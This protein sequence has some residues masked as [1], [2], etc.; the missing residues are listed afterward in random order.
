MATLPPSTAEV[1]EFRCQWTHNVTQKKKKWNDGSLKF[2]TFNKL[3]RIFDE[4]SNN[5]GQKHWQGVSLQDGDEFQLDNVLVSV[6]DHLRSTQTNLVP[7]FD[8]RK[9]QLANDSGALLDCSHS[10]HVPRA[11]TQA[12]LSNF[13]S[14]L[15]GP[16]Q[17]H[18]SAGVRSK[19]KSLNSLL[20]TAKGPIGK[21]LASTS[22]YEARN[23][24]VFESHVEE[25]AAKRK[26]TEGPSGEPWTLTNTTNGAST[27]ASK[28][29]KHGLEAGTKRQGSANKKAKFMPATPGQKT[30]KV[31]SV[32]D[33]T[34]DSPRNLRVSVGED[35]LVVPPEKLYQPREI[36]PISRATRESQ[37]SRNKTESMSMGPPASRLVQP[38][39]TGEF[40]RA[41]DRTLHRSDTQ[42]S[43][44]LS[45]NKLPQQR[46]G[47]GKGKSL[48]L[49][50]VKRKPMLLCMQPTNH[51]PP[52][53]DETITISDDEINESPRLVDKEIAFEFDNSDID[54]TSDA[55]DALSSPPISRTPHNQIKN[56]RQKDGKSRSSPVV[57]R[58]RHEAGN[59]SRASLRDLVQRSNRLF[60]QQGDLTKM[61]DQQ[62]LSP[63]RSNLGR[64]QSDPTAMVPAGNVGIPLQ[65]DTAT[66]VA[67]RQSRAAYTRAQSVYAATTK[68]QA[69]TTIFT[70]LP[71][72]KDADQEDL[73]PWSREAM[74]LFDWRP[75]NWEERLAQQPSTVGMVD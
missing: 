75:P 74:D 64:S 63:R 65:S 25:P 20:G 39:G 18:S 17:T 54:L 59:S 29:I 47:N 71:P 67:Q 51:R 61:T 52:H 4:D 53:H 19:H 11:N 6:Q 30:F 45:A 46:N 49:S 3:V 42:K 1:I 15:S 66:I 37:P 38:R 43:Q 44:L 9:K 58:T 10:S 13:A 24:R 27:S 31:K 2:H 7:L 8:K 62:Q 36:S 32:V 73:G 56:R 16:R 69:P 41:N 22:P 55:I 12:Q 70:Q 50:T 26:R 21:A 14:P 40:D 48:A 28:S 23:N 34:S 72:E 68:F 5:V 60:G 57:S 35:N 33:L